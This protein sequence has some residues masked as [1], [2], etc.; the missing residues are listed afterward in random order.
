MSLSILPNIITIMRIILIIPFAYY[1][2]VEQYPLALVIFLIAGLSDGLDGLLAKRFRWQSRFGSI[3]DPLADKL[4]LLVALLLLVVKG[5]ISWTL[6]WVSTAR[7]VII[8]GGATS[9][10]YLVGPYEMRPSLI[11]KWN[12]ALLI[13][14]VLLVLLTVA[15]WYAVPEILL[16]GL[17]I[18][19][20]LTC[21][22]SGLHYIWLGFANYKTVKKQNQSSPELNEPPEK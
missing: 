5:H 21:I 4:L 15:E 3:T 17:E 12:T 7:D 16:Q 6:F 14:L 9:Y 13:L 18:I 19:V 11:S 8:V 1:V 20:I 2:M 22:I 10:H